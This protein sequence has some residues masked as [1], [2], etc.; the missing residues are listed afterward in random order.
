MKK[1]NQTYIL[2]NPVYIQETASIVGRK[3]GNGP[4]GK[5]FDKIAKIDTF[6]ED[7]FEKAEREMFYQT[8]CLLLKKADK[9][10]DDIDLLLSGDLNNQIIASNYMASYLKIPF[11]GV[12]S[13]CAT[14]AGALG[15]GACLISGKIMKNVMCMAGSHFSTAERQY[16]FPLEFGNQ[17]QT[18]SQ[19]TVTGVGA[20]LLSSSKTYIKIRKVCFGKVIDFG[21]KD[22]ANMGAAMAPAAMDTL[23]AFFGDTNTKPEDYDVIATGDLGKLGSDI[24]LDL[25]QEKGY[26]LGQNYIDCGNMI[27]G[28]TDDSNQGGSGAGCSATVFNSYFISKLKE[29]K[30][31]KMILVSTGALMSTITN[32]QG[33]TIPCTAHAVEVEIC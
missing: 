13:A 30:I 2:D 27:Y 28:V 9:K 16:R 8:A 15:L 7:T 32:Q 29:K 12:Y 20:T 26:S 4:V 31:K 25:M 24:L 33:E 5:Y 22:I 14:F 19:W 17:R 21:V 11:V 1:G 23:V 10:F 6:N 18:Y 3:E